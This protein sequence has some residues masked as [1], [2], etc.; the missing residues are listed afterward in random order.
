MQIGF[1]MQRSAAR[2]RSGNLFG[3]NAV[4][5]DKLSNVLQLLQAEAL[6][7][8]GTLRPNLVVDFTR[9]AD[10]A[11]PSHALKVRGDIHSIAIDSGFIMDDVPPG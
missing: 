1:T 8:N 9:D 6:E 11:G 5:V 3:L 10:P 7:G 4:D 2:I